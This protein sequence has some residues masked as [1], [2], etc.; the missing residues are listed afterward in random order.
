MVS[1]II[2]SRL[3]KVVDPRARMTYGSARIGRVKVAEIM[4]AGE[5]YEELIRDF[6]NSKPATVAKP[7]L[8]KLAQN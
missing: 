8:N 4:Q 7:L 1:D 3:A 6:P 2:R 5:T